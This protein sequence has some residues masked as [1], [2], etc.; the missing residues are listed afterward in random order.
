MVATGKNHRDQKQ[1]STY[2]SKDR[3]FFEVTAHP[4]R[5]EDDKALG[6]VFVYRDQT[7]AHQLQEQLVQSEKLAS[8]GL[9]AGGIAHEINNPLGGIMVFSQML[10]REMPQ[11]SPHYPDVEEILNATERCK[12]IVENLLEF[13]RTKSDHLPNKASE[14]VSVDD[15]I[16]TALRFIKIG[17]TTDSIDVS[18]DLKATDTVIE[19]DRNRLIQVFLNLMQNAVQAMPDGGRLELSTNYDSNHIYC[20]I[21]DTGIGISAEQLKRIF[22]PF[23][24]TKDPGEGTGLGL[25]ICYG[26]IQDLGGTIK[27]DSRVNHGTNFTIKLP[28]K[29][30]VEQSA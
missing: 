19:G 10:L 15:A 12:A 3:R 26:I 21:T 25:A 17:M 13:A 9:L 2:E 23:F 27:V 28:R 5:G 14:E 4:H 6:Y 16:N 18:M 7:E 24:T 8:I 29:T 20:N 30:G 11:D 22:D 1:V